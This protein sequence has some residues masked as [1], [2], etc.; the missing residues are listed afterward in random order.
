ME[1]ENVVIAY[2]YTCIPDDQITKKVMLKGHILSV[3]PQ[4]DTVNIYL[5]AVDSQ[6]NEFAREVLFASDYGSYKIRKSDFKESVQ[7]SQEAMAIA[8]DAYIEE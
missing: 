8:F 1:T 3:P 6:G 4:S 2:A 7:F 5:L